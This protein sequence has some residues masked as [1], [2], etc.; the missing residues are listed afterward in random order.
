MELESIIHPPVVTPPTKYVDEMFDYF[1][2][3]NARAAAVI[4]EFGGVEGLVTM[5]DVLN[6]IFGEISEDVAGQ[7][8][9]QERDSNVFEVRGDMKLTDF[10]D[11]TNFDIEDPRMTTIG[12]VVS[13]Y[14][15]RLP[16][17]GDT[18]AL[19]GY[20]AT[21]LEMDGHRLARVR[22]AK[23]GLEDVLGAS[24][25]ESEHGDDDPAARDKEKDGLSRSARKKANKKKHPRKTSRRTKRPR[26]SPLARR[27][28][29]IRNRIMR[30]QMN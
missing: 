11:L 2:S 3:H 17:V 18:V 7:D 12:G 22:V 24:G 6:F 28:K 13:R 25:E 1:Q 27:S 30:R 19:D 5:R 14:L 9:Y 26:T 10:D 16:K 20:V 23:G 4:N 8:L 29:K 21:V 15:D